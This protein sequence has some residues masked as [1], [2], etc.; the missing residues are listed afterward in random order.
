M[1]VKIDV[2][3]GPVTDSQMGIDYVKAE[4][5]LDAANAVNGSGWLATLVQERMDSWR[6]Q[7]SG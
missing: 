6:S 7:T 4:L 3:S 1:G 5:G 2:V